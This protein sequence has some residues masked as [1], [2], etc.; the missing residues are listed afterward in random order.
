[1]GM[2]MFSQ[3]FNGEDD[4]GEEENLF[5]GARLDTPEDK[6]VF[7]FEFKT[8]ALRTGKGFVIRI[9]EGQYIVCFTDV[10]KAIIILKSEMK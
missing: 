9:S 6:G 7:Y 3:A 5:I 1:M 4:S 10:N 8:S 2:Y